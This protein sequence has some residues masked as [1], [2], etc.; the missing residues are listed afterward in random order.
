MDVSLFNAPE[1]E[2]R[3]RVSIPIRLLAALS[4]IL[5]IIGVVV[6]SM[7]VSEMFVAMSADESAG[8][9]QVM[10]V[11]TSASFAATGFLYVAIVCGLVVVVVLVRRTFIPTKTAPPPVWFFVAAGVL[12][13]LPTWLYW[14]A[15]LLVL[16]AVSPNSSI[17]TDEMASTGAYI[18]ELLVWSIG[19]AI[20]ASIALVVLAVVPL[21][22]GSIN[23]RN[24]LIGATAIEVLLIGMAIV[25]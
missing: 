5:P 20:I 18:A 13:L 4:C 23:T 21:S 1:A 16:E 9:D 10:E 24:S 19:A 2:P 12:C 11:M 25:V 3:L 15:H 6:S 22:S 8:T 14:K 17:P 7:L